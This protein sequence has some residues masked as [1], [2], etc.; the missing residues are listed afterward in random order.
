MENLYVKATKHS[1]EIDLN[2][3]GTII[4]KGRSFPENTFEF[5]APMMNWIKN[6][7]K[8]SP[9]QDTIIDLEVTYCN[10]GST[11]LFFD[12]FDILI[13]NCK[14]NNIVVNWHYDEENDTMEEMG[15]DIKEEF[16]DLNINLIITK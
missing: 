12:L 13:Q 2:T 9:A 6:Y 16:S 4:L 5:Y 10:S 8:E 3:N 7:F 15:T 14:N 1:L 11:M